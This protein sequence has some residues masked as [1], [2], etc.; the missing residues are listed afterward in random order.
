MK[1]RT[2]FLLIL[3][4][5]LIQ[6][7]SLVAQGEWVELNYIT[8]VNDFSKLPLDTLWDYFPDGNVSFDSLD[9]KA[10]W[11]KANPVYLNDA[12]GKPLAW[13]GIGWFRQKFSVPDSLNGKLIALRIGHFG[14]SEIYLDDKPIAQFG[15]VFAVAGKNK[16]Y[17]PRKPITGMLD[18]TLTH[19]LEVRYA[20]H[21]FDK[22]IQPRIFFGFCL[23]LAPVSAS[24]LPIPLQTY[25]E[26][27]SASIY[28]AF[29]L[30][31]FLVYL[32]YPQRRSG[33]FTGLFLLN[34]SALFTSVGIAASAT[35]AGI[36]TWSNLIW[37]FS[38]AS[39]SG[40]FLLLMYAIYYKKMPVRTWLVVIS[41]I[42]NLLAVIYPVLSNPFLTLINILIGAEAWRIIIIGIRDK[43]LGF[44]ILFV[45]QLVGTIFFLI[46]IADVFHLYSLESNQNRGFGELGGLISDISAPLMLSLYLAWEFGSAN[47]DLQKQLREVNKL[48][49]ENLEKEQE[50]QQILAT[51][52]ET[53]EK[54]VTERT[55]ALNQS[56]ENLKATQN[57][58]IQSEKLA[59][60]GELTAGIAHEIQNPLNFVNNFSELSI[61]LTK[62]LNEE[63]DKE[64]VDKV[65]VK[66]LM[67]DLTGNQEKINFHGKRAASIVSGMLEHSR[68]STGSRDAIHRVFTDINKLADEYFRLSYHGLRAK[69]K[70]FNA[71][72]ITHF[73]AT[74]PKIEIIPQDVGRVILNLINNAFYAVNER[75]LN[76]IKTVG[77]VL[78][79][80][81][82]N[83]TPTVTVSTTKTE[84]AIEIHVKDNG[85]GMSEAVREKVFQPFFTTKPTG[86]GTGLGL[87]LAYDIIT[88]GHSGSLKVESTEG[89]GSEFIIQ[90]PFKS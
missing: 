16:S 76:E 55:T 15:D 60:L 83:Y 17:L 88:K 45:G 8:E 69:N 72:M 11:Q 14:A 51:Q 23:S 33:L 26:V 41:L 49:K 37:K 2:S 64:P 77:E 20:T 48:S 43:R 22:A 12:S 68:A 44:W 78:N 73:D 34:F 62:E 54:Q 3:F 46:F 57:Q 31:F 36:S 59:S 28:I 4:F 67:Y 35:D 58:L 25:H 30:F 89:V 70:D 90:L 32:F 42:I 74:I 66:E 65:F 21:S 56:L 61:D 50:K 75:R 52:N 63:I 84:N 6:M 53:L 19:T 38:V 13:S 79:L 86:Q 5:L 7:S 71:E 87:S 85:I 81:D 18:N 10:I 27:F 24:Y 39:I 1:N 40:W 29:T 82:G 9:A 47:R 80:A